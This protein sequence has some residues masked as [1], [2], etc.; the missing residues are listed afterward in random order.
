MPADVAHDVT[1]PKVTPKACE[2][3][4]GTWWPPLF[5]RTQCRDCEKSKRGAM[6]RGKLMMLGV[7]VSQHLS[8][9]AMGKARGGR[10]G[11]EPDSGKPTVR[12][13]RGAWG[14][15]VYDQWGK[16]PALQELE[17]EADPLD[18]RAPVLPRRITADKAV[19]LPVKVRPCQLPGFGRVAMPRPV[20]G[21]HA[22]SE[23]CICLRC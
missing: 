5:T 21:N 1:A 19:T 9:M 12:D 4:L 2:G 6:L 14:N 15:V 3:A 8:L 7:Y 16:P 10:P 18:A 22:G 13:R 11:S 17:T 23:R 20:L